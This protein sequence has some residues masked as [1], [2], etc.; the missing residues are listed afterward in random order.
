MDLDLHTQ[1]VVVLIQSITQFGS[2][3]R[4]GSRVRIMDSADTLGYVFGYRNMKKAAIL[5]P[6]AQKSLSSGHF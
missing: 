3:T 5:D 1:M 6:I 2:L 4:R